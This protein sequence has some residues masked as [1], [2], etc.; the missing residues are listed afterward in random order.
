MD[1]PIPEQNLIPIKEAIFRGRKIET[2]KLYRKA[3]GAGLAEAK[4][5]VEKLEAELRS[6]SPERFTAPAANKGCS[7]IAVVCCL[8]ALAAIVWL[9]SK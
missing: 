6:A 4:I 9:L 5:A 2:I 7:G 8:G 3:T 1:Q